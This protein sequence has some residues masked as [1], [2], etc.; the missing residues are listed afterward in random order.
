[1]ATVIERGIGDNNPP[2][3]TPLEAFRAFVD[4]LYVEAQNFLDGEPIATEGQAEAVNKLLDDARK[5]EKDG[6]AKRK[7]MTK[8]L[9]EAKAAIMDEWR[10]LVDPKTG[11]CKLIADTCKKALEPRCGR[12]R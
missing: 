4:D 9:D 7:E 8:P 5:A 3:P 11:R 1:M 2:E 6:E 10:P 12:Q